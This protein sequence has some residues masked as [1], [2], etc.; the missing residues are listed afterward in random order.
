MPV[1]VLLWSNLNP[2]SR[3][4]RN[5]NPWY[6]VHDVQ[7]YIRTVLSPLGT[8]VPFS[9]RWH[10]QTFQRCGSNLKGLAHGGVRHLYRGEIHQFML[11]GPCPNGP[12]AGA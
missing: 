2:V 7:F 11:L 9:V 10:S 4:A 1:L 8:R 5:G 3:D 12:G 6:L